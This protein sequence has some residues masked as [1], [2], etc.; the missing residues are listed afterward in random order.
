M[1]KFQN[2]ILNFYQFPKEEDKK[3]VLDFYNLKGIIKDAINMID[4]KALQG[5]PSDNIP[6][7]KGIGEKTAIKLLQEYKTVEGI[8]ENIESIKGANKQKLIEDKEKAFETATCL[9]EDNKNRQAEE[10]AIML[11]AEEIIKRAFKLKKMPKK[12]ILEGVVSSKKQLIPALML[13]I[14]E[15][16]I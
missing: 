9:D 1:S 16:R 7:V 8:Y 5:D 10:H 14:Q 13:A 4:L 15:E 6:G 3:K 12:V 11:E 2:F